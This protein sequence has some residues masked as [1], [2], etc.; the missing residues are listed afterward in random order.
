MGLR[1]SAALAEET[2]DE[3]AQCGV[4]R[5]GKVSV[6]PQLSEQGKAETVE[7]LIIFQREKSS[8]KA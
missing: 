2:G 3:T 5:T 1:G 4:R 7:D 8:M 6:C